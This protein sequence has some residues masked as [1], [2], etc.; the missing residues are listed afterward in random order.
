MREVGMQSREEESGLTSL[1]NGGFGN[2]CQQAFANPKVQGTY[3]WMNSGI[4]SAY[5]PPLGMGS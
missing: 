1:F 4:V 5:P 2:D 3:P